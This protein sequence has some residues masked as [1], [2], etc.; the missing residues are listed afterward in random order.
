[1][2]L[3]RKMTSIGTLGAVDLHSDKERIA[4][5]TAKMNRSVK[6]QT[7]VL[8]QQNRLIRDQASQPLAVLPAMP[9]VVA[10]PPSVTP[11]GP[12]AGWYQDAARP[13]MLR[14]YDGTAWSEFLQP[15]TESSGESPGAPNAVDRA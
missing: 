15:K 4:R 9:V 11:Q 1:M 14:W 2:G 10:P 3:F 7:K 5:N 12:P 8:R 13:D 6:S